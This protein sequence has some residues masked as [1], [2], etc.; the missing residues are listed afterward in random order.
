MEEKLVT[1]TS[2]IEQ[3]VKLNVCR[4]LRILNELTLISIQLLLSFLYFIFKIHYFSAYDFYSVFRSL[5]GI[6]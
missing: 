5:N 6:F 2:D 3:A 4:H 1:D